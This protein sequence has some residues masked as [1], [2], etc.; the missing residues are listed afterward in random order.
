MLGLRTKWGVD[1]SQLAALQPLSEQWL[2]QKNQFVAQDMMLETDTHL[3]LTPAG[4]LLADAI[5]S[6]LFV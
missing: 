4:R 6:D 2:R 3:L 1:K 5:A